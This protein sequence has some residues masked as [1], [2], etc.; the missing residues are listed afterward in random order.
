MHCEL[1]LMLG[2]DYPYSEFLPRKGA[3]MLARK[4]LTTIRACP[5]TDDRRGDYPDH[6]FDFLVCRS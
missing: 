6:N 1:L 5:R 2:T 3:V 4:K